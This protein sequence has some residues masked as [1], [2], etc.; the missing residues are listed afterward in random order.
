M[1]ISSGGTFDL[2][3][4]DQTIGSL[5]ST[6]SL[7]QVSLGFGVLTT[8]N[9]NTSTTFAG[10][11]SDNGRGGGLTKIGSGAFVL[12]GS[13]TYTGATTISNGTLQLGNGDMTGSIDGSSGVVNN[14]VLAFNRS[15]NVV[16]APSISGSGGVTQRGTGSLLLTAQNTYTGTTRI[17]S[18]TLAIALPVVMP[19]PLAH[20]TMDGTPG[21]VSNGATITNT[22]SGA[23]LDGQMVGTGASYVAGIANQGITLNGSQYIQTPGFGA[24]NA[25]TDSVWINLPTAT[26]NNLA[27][28]LDGRNDGAGFST[29]QSLNNGGTTVYSRIESSSGTVDLY[30]GGVNF[31]ITPNTWHMLTFTVQAGAYD[32]YLDGVLK[33]AITLSAGTPQLMNAGVHYTIGA[34][35]SS[36]S[37]GVQGSLDDFNLYSSVLTGDQIS[38]LYL[39][40]KSGL[41]SG[42]P[43]Q[44]A[45]GGV[46]DMAGGQQT[47][48]SLS[49]GGG[50]GGGRVI[51]SNTGTTST[52][53]LSPTGGR[54]PSPARSPAAAGRAPLAW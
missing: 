41:P 53:T 5:S 24:L 8:G 12:T 34:D 14:G 38:R 26:V 15:D 10:V 49:D 18:G 25:W 46:F 54:P 2:N 40:E 16:F 19:T 52:L 45:S 47:V 7:T 22:G 43:M 1:T 13:N 30:E 42:T 44:V 21:P 28:L 39:I 3:N 29:N 36:G 23:G 31:T 4:L 6:D 37:Y 11:I 17:S 35:A 20:Y 48:S 32:I 50:G 9:D 51:N 27:Y 33:N